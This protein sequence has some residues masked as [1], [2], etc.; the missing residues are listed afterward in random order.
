MIDQNPLFDFGTIEEFEHMPVMGYKALATAY[1]DAGRTKFAVLLLDMAV[2][3]F[4]NDLELRNML[5]HM[6]RESEL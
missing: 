6:R 4:P 2:E 3:N 5:R 1:R